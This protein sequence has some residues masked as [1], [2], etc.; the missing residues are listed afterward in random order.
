[1]D[2]GREELGAWSERLEVRC[3][4]QDYQEA[5]R[6]GVGRLG[7]GRGDECFLGFQYQTLDGLLICGLFKD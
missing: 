6:W 2:N 7:P 5:S 4:G 3:Q 1:M